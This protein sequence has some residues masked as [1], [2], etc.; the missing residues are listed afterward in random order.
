[1]A[2]APKRRGSVAL[3]RCSSERD[4]IPTCRR[5]GGARRTYRQAGTGLAFPP[6]DCVKQPLRFVGAG[7]SA[8]V[9]YRGKWSSDLVT[10]GARV[11][12]WRV[13]VAVLVLI[14]F[15]FMA[16]QRDPT[17]QLV[18]HSQQRV[19]VALVFVVA[20]FAV[21]AGWIIYCESPPVRVGIFRHTPGSSF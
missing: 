15:P 10:V 14:G 21:I 11:V 17:E 1:S 2:R 3:S 19:F 20:Y 4:P 6:R 13:E 16:V 18:L 9:D 7:C 8:A 12:D 5:R